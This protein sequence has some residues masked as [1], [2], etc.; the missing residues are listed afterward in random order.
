MIVSGLPRRNRAV[1]NRM[2]LNEKVFGEARLRLK[3]TAR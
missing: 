3:A 1:N 2:R